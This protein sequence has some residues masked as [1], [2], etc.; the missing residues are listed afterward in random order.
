MP[1]IR[2]EDLRVVKTQKSLLAAMSLLLERRGFKGI[3]VNDICEEAQIS[4]TTFYAHY[5]D[6]FD[7]L[8]HW[9]MHF[10]LEDLSKKDTYEQ[11]EESVNKFVHNHTDI[12]KHLVYDADN[13]TLDLLF[14]FLNYTLMTEKNETLNPK[15]VVLS[16]FYIG[17][18]LNYITWQVKNNFPPEVTT[19]NVYLYELIKKVR[20]LES[21]M[22]APDIS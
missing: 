3:T 15:Y 7:L 5:V 12:I 20:E 6:K 18:M 16:N 10:N 14:D 19:M 2:K 22:D 11:L 4:R 13:E 9:L 17:G 8:K 1:F 21:E